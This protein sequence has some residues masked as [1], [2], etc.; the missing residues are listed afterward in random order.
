MNHTLTKEDLLQLKILADKITIDTVPQETKMKRER[1]PSKRKDGRY[2]LYITDENKK[3]KAIYGKTEEEVLEKVHK[4]EEEIRYKQTER[5]FTFDYLYHEWFKNLDI[6][7]QSKDRIEVT[8]NKYFLNTQFSKKDIRTFT[9]KYLLDYINNLLKEAEVMKT[10]EY[11]KVLQIIQSTILQPDSNVVSIDW[12]WIKSKINKTRLSSS[13]KKQYSI[14]DKVK[15]Q[16]EATILNGTLNKKQRLSGLCIL[17]NFS[18]GVRIGELSS[19]FW[20]DIDFDN[21]T[22][23]ITTTESKAFKR[24]SNGNRI[25]VTQYAVTPPKT[26]E[27]YRTIPFTDK[28]YE[29]LLRIKDYQ[30]QNGWFSPNQRI[31]YSGYDYVS[32]VSKLSKDLDTICKVA[33]IDH[34][35][36]HL[37][38]KTFASN[39]HHGHVP[40]KTIS[41]LLGHKKITTTLDNY[42][43]SDGKDPDTLREAISGTV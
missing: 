20:S 11:N 6:T 36:T 33:G 27:S 31:C 22:V 34:I 39:L 5:L 12:P 17:L 4:L 1:K 19:I 43:L 7:P 32:Y 40:T 28:S 16:L 15:S 26:E 10:K 2:M 29:A 41:T 24:D 14:K 30:E 3:R 42:I 8:Y 25:G 18:L 38:R 35:N 21:R 9:S 37:V 13:S 23:N